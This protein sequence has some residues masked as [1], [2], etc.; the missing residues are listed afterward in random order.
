MFETLTQSPDCSQVK[1]ELS[2]FQL[3]LNAAFDRSCFS[4][5]HLGVLEQ[6]NVRRNVAHDGG[7]RLKEPTLSDGI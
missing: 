7:S 1:P 3:A 2:G 4:D 6:L 5:L